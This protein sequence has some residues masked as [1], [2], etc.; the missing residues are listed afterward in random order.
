MHKFI[1]LFST[2]FV[3]LI[4]TIPSS[5]AHFGMI[6]PSSNIIEQRDKTV[7]LKLSFSHPFEGIGMNMVKPH[8]FYSTTGG[9]KTDLL[10]SLSST[11][12][13]GHQSWQLTQKIQRPGVYSYIVEPEPYW[14]PVEDVHII[15]YTKTTIAA[16]GD[17]HGWDTQVP[18]RTNQIRR[19]GLYPL[20]QRV[21]IRQAGAAEPFP[22]NV[23][24]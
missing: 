3:F 12:I 19:L 9:S 17:D 1:P 2:V 23:P 6:I 20:H 7:Q 4:V 21:H 14:E 5:Y 11:T 24:K 10:Q 16:F 18:I 8:K 15:H 13:M 22:V